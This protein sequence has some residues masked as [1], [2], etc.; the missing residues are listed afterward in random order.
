MSVDRVGVERLATTAQRQPATSHLETEKYRAAHD[1]HQ[2][3]PQHADSTRRNSSLAIY[4]TNATFY[5][6]P[7]GQAIIFCS[8]G[9]Y[10]CSFFLLFSSPILSGRR[11]DANLECRSEMCRMRFAENAGRKIRQKFAICAPSHKFVG[12]YR[13]NEGKYRQSEKKLAKEQYFLYMSSQYGE[14][15]LTNG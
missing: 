3:R 11:V 10:R 12:L 2:R 4:T 5:G 6:R 15:R 14:L 13:H 9:F 8:C 7:I 1:D